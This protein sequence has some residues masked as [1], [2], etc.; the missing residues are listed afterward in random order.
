MRWML[1]SALAVV[2]ALLA[3]GRASSAFAAFTTINAPIFPGE[4]DS[5]QILEHLYNGTFTSIAPSNLSYTN[6]TITATRI[7]DIYQPPIIQP[8]LVLANE[9]P[10]NDDQ[11]WQ[12]NFL[13]S[14]ATAVFA[15]Y[16]QEFGYYDG[17]SGGSY[18]KLFSATGV[19]YGATGSADLSSL[20]GH[21]LRWARG[22]QSRV[23][24]SKMSDNSDQRDHMVTYQITGLNDNKLTWLV[25]WEDKLPTEPDADFDFNDL[26]VQIKATPIAIPEPT[27]TVP[28]GL[29]VLAGLYGKRQLRK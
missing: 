21:T 12:A 11:T 4:K 3:I 22:G 29:M 20:A 26:V 19:E 28:L 14:S 2:V 13:L 18:V 27:A 10:I 1:H 15:A 5:K 9:G 7:E 25:M 17:A 16:N 24:S 23:F 6:G 8:A